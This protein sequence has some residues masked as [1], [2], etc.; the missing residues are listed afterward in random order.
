MPPSPDWCHCPSCRAFVWTY[1]RSGNSLGAVQWTDGKLIGAMWPD[2]SG[3]RRC[4]ACRGFVWL[5]D[6][7]FSPR[8]ASE[9]DS[10]TEP[11]AVVLKA[12]GSDR[13]GVFRVIRSYFS[14]PLHETKALVESPPVTL[15]ARTNEGAKELHQALVEVGASASLIL[16]LEDADPEPE[17]ELA[18]VSDEELWEV[19]PHCGSVERIV[20]VRTR[21][22]WVANDRDRGRWS[23]GDEVAARAPAWTERDIDNASDLAA[24]LD[25]ERP[26]DRVFL[27]E[28]AREGGG[29]E[30]MMKPLLQDLPAALEPVA[31]QMLSLAARG[32][33][34]V[35]PLAQE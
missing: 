31:A 13:I 29:G 15:G 11:P 34:I 8:G 22:V 16:D 26:E 25:R 2:D 33:R 9:G 6:A 30:A 23:S 4:P 32:I 24:L 21:L 10:L 3:I 14:W 20:Q 19:I 27:A 1:Q 28:L 35:A 18:K 17:H 12:V 5:E 7:R